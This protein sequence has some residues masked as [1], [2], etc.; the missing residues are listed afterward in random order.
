MPLHAGLLFENLFF[1]K[2]VVWSI[3]LHLICSHPLNCLCNYRGDTASSRRLHDQGVRGKT[4]N[5]SRVASG[6][7]S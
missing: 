6:P 5:T 2:K 3:V 4:R 7:L 1:G